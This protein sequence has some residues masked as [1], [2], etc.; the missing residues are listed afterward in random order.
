M[1]VTSGSLRWNGHF[2]RDD[3]IS[4]VILI[5]KSTAIFYN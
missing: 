2:Q 3:I 5:N 1:S 4:I